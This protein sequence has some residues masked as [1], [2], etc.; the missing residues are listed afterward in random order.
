MIIESLEKIYN[1][2][3]E[4][5]I[6]LTNFSYKFE[7]G[8]FYAIMGTSGSGKSTLIKILGL[9]DVLTSGKYFI[10]EKDVSSL[11]DTELSSIRMNNIGFIFQD[12]YLDKNL[13]AYENVMVPMLIN[14]S[15][16][17]EKRKTRACELLKALGLGDRLKHFP[18]ELS[19]GE[20]QRVCIAR[21]LANNPDYILA[22][23][24]TG[25][26]DENN[27]VRIMQILKQ[28]SKSGKCI[29]VVSH[30]NEILKYADE[31]L[32]LKGGKLVNNNEDY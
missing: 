11:N 5:V 19:G 9:M 17:K 8:K 24:P 16:E 1:T 15:I 18:K 4:K 6:A 26:L 3:T 28:L 25:N 31:V 27:E 2:S 23:E 22:D 32:K 20:Q 14:K 21:S 7:K 30:S 13:R 29:I 10:N 12:Y